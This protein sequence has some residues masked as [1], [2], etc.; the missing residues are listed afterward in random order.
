MNNSDNKFEC[1]IC[2][3]KDLNEI[4]N[5]E[6]GHEFHLEC[7]NNWWETGSIYCPLCKKKDKL[8]EMKKKHNDAMREIASQTTVI[9]PE[10]SFQILSSVTYCSSP[11]IETQLTVC[12]ETTLEPSTIVRGRYVT[13]RQFIRVVVDTSDRQVYCFLP[14][15]YN[16]TTFLEIVREQ[17]KKCLCF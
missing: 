4:I 15:Y 3:S 2:L 13:D 12:P 7:I 10:V 9:G 6:C 8:Q 17:N 14:I 16:N 11:N 1:S 5:L